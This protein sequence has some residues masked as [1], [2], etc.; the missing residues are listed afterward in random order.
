[1]NDHCKELIEKK[2]REIRLL[3]IDIAQEE[4]LL[5]SAGLETSL[6]LEALKT[7]RLG[8]SEYI[9]GVRDAYNAIHLTGNPL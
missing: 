7:K 4:T 9:D 3:N 8:C 1:M 5:R 6:F 2:E